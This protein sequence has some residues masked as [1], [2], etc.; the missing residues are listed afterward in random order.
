MKRLKRKLAKAKRR[1]IRFLLKT[2][3]VAIVLY[4]VY[5]I[6]DTTIIAGFV[7]NRGQF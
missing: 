5:L 4:M 3:G 6:N 1:R 2:L 7:I